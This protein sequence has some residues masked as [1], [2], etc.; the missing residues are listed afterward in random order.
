MA[1]AELIY[2]VHP[3][4]E[5]LRAN[6]EAVR[7]VYVA[8]KVADRKVEEIVDLSR[9]A[10]VEITRIPRKELSNRLGD[11]V[12]QGVALETSPFRFSELSDLFALAESRGERP[13]FLA[14]DHV[15]DPHNFGAL[16]RSAYALG[17]HGILIPKNRSAPVTPTVLK[18]SAGAI[19]HLPIVQVTNLSRSLRDLKKQGMWIVGTVAENASPLAQVDFTESIGLVIGSEGKGLREKVEEL[20]DFRAHIPMP[21][22]LG[23]LN[24]SVAGGICLY[25]AARQRSCGG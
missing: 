16:A 25:E 6:P 20:C 22:K 9:S 13:L 8:D 21:G 1:Q 12:H 3:V 23:S 4:L 11:A 17:A 19:V 18:S 10:G 14:L 15:Q 24:A 5:M 7:R 2:G